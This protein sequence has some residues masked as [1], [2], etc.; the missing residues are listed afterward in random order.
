M[1]ATVSAGPET[2]PPRADAVAPIRGAMEGR[3][4]SPFVARRAMNG[5][6]GRPIH[7]R[8]D[9]GP[10]G[11]AL[12]ADTLPVDLVAVNPSS[13]VRGAPLMRFP[14]PIRVGD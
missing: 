9:D 4:A 13:A 1:L 12:P 3:D 7:P 8:A 10:N 11:V 6:E 2:N 5:L 14:A